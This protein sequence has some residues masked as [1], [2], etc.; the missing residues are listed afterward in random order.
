MDESESRGKEPAN[1]E[2][3]CDISSFSH[4]DLIEITKTTLNEVLERDSLLSDLPRDV[5]LEE[6]NAQIALEHGQSMTVYVDRADGE[7][8]PVVVKHK[9]ATVLDLK[10]AIQRHLMWRMDRLQKKVKISWKYIWKTYHLVYDS[11]RLVKD[12]KLLSEI[13]IRNKSRVTFVKR[14]RKKGEVES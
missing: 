14:L 9:D 12:E 6:V 3:E 7:E 8:L 2:D 4:K 5:T 10:R 13:G 1:N 11:E